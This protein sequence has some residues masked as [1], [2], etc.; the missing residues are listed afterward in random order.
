M[1]SSNLVVM[2]KAMWFGASSVISDGSCK[3]LSEQ[4]TTN[5]FQHESHDVLVVGITLLIAKHFALSAR[6]PSLSLMLESVMIQINGSLILL[7]HV[8]LI[9]LQISINY[10]V[11]NCYFLRLVQEWQASD[12]SRLSTWVRIPPTSNSTFF[13]LRFMFVSTRN[14]NLMFNVMRRQC[15]LLWKFTKHEVNA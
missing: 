15:W 4:N 9:L 5:W 12:Y 1:L 11:L 7:C 8:Q 14:Q 10:V 3:L 6:S 13:L 2:N